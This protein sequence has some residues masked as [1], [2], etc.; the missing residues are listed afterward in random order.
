MRATPTESATA[1]P[2]PADAY[3]HAADRALIPVSMG[4]DRGDA[5]FA[6][7]PD[8]TRHDGALLATGSH[9]ASMTHVFDAD[10]PRM[11]EW[12]REDARTAAEGVTRD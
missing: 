5:Y 7:T 1:S 2:G 8:L 4:P 9:T 10:D 6:L 12:R 11:E 3:P